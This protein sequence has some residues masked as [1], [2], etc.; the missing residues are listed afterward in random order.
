MTD[1]KQAGP[2]YENRTR[3]NRRD[4]KGGTILFFHFDG[5]NVRNRLLHETQH[6]EGAF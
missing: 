3:G 6:C 2:E 4:G 1:V 5:T